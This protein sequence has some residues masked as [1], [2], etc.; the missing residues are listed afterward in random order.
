M[1][2]HQDPC[3]ICQRIEAC[4]RGTHPG[5]VAELDTGYVVLGDSQHWPG[6]ALLLARHPVTELH[7]LPAAVRARHLADV[8]L[9]AEAVGRACAPHKLN[10]ESLGNLVHHL[11]WHVFPRRADEPDPRAP[12]WGQMPQGAAAE[13]ARLDARRHAGLKRAL[14]EALDALAGPGS[15][16]A[17]DRRRVATGAWM[18]LRE[19]GAGPVVL[20]VHGFPLTGALWE[21]VAR[22]LVD[23]GHRVLAPDLRGFGQSRGDPAQTLATHADD[24][25]ALLDALAIEGPV[26]WVGFSMGGY[27]ALEAWRRH[28][29]RVGALALVDTQA[30][31]DDEKGR[32]GRQALARR[33]EAEGS[34]VVA[35]AMLPRLFG[36]AAAPDLA[37]E[38]RGRMRAADPAAVAAALRAMGARPDSRGD[39]PGI[40]VPVTVVVGAEDRITPPAL[41]RAMAGAIPGALLR[42]VPGAG[43]MAPVEQPQAVAEALLEGLA[44]P[45]P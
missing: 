7:E 18:A 43:H 32:A 8:A 30:G 9:L 20:L 27:V 23:A 14:A 44:R 36:P 39:L 45:R 37:E 21:P 42:E 4:R 33:V 35:D 24:L 16:Q 41:A 31:A 38:W 29:G 10:V 11:H 3:E 26:A 13:A 17:L 19:R 2:R 22:R 15:E 1:A 28:R 6:Y 40:A 12:V 5:L 25:V 34:V